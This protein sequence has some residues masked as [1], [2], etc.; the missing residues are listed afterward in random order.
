M[1]GR[2]SRRSCSTSARRRRLAV[3]PH[4]QPV[5]RVVVGSGGG[6]AHGR[7]RVRPDAVR[8][9]GVRAARPCQPR[10]VRGHQ[11]RDQPDDVR[12]GSRVGFVRRDR[13]CG[14]ARL[15]RDRPDPRL[16]RHGR[17]PRGARVARPRRPPRPT[18]GGRRRRRIPGVRAGTH[19][20]SSAAGAKRTAEQVR[21]EGAEAVLLQADIVEWARVA[22]DG[23]R[24]LRQARRG[25]RPGQQRGRCRARADVV[26]RHDRGVDRPRSG[27]RHQG[28]HGVHPRVR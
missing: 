20:R 14:R 5:H 16:P 13:Q 25:R 23:R 24:S 21:G 15:R 7:R 28:R 8:L 18:A 19:Y 9:V 27:R 1:S 26:A 10:P 22:R 17:P 3:D 11:G 2:T 4:P 6:A 12:D